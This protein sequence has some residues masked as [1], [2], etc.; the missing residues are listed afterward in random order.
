MSIERYLDL[1]RGTF[2]Q[3]PTATELIIIWHKVNAIRESFGLPPIEI[4][5]LWRVP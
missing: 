2:T 1:E 3:E 4:D 5:E